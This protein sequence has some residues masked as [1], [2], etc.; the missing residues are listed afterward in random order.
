MHSEQKM[1][2]TAGEYIAMADALEQ[3][4]S[5]QHIHGE[6]FDLLIFVDGEFVKVQ[7][8]V[9]R[10][11]RQGRN[12]SFR[13]M[14]GRLNARYYTEE[15]VDVFAF[16]RMGDRTVAWVHIAETSLSRHTIDRELF[17]E[18]NL[19]RALSTHFSRSVMS[20]ISSNSS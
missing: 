14:K 19:E 10:C 8:K 5:C 2:G 17:R 18:F 3:Y 11:G 7:V 20:G 9:E 13:P 15:E 16:V 4:I 6:P 12:P 1:L